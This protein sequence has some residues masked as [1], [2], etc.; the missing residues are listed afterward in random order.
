VE[1]N[2]YEDNVPAAM[3][4]FHR[5]ECRNGAA[6]PS[7]DR[8]ERAVGSRFI[9]AMRLTQPFRRQSEAATPPVPARVPKQRRRRQLASD[10]QLATNRSDTVDVKIAC[11]QAAAFVRIFA[12]DS[13]HS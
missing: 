1:A 2:F 13:V 7:H 4:Q 3:A 8:K 9:E 11:V 10:K 12:A 5:P 6:L